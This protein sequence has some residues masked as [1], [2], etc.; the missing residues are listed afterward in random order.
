M[1]THLDGNS[2]SKLCRQRS[3]ALVC[4]R[5]QQLCTAA[6]QLLR[7]IAASFLRGARR[8]ERLCSF[9]AWL[10][11]HAAGRVQQLSLDCS[12]QGAGD[13]QLSA[14]VAAAIS[15]CGAAGSLTALRVKDTLC[16]PGTWTSALRG[17]RRLVAINSHSE[18]ALMAWAV[19]PRALAGLQAL[20]VVGFNAPLDAALP[21]SLTKLHLDYDNQALAMPGTA[22]LPTKLTALT[23][24][25]TLHITCAGGDFAALPQ[26]PS[27]CRLALVQ[28][29]AWPVCL[30]QLTRMQALELANAYGELDDREAAA[31]AVAAALPRLQVTHLLLDWPSNTTGL[32][33]EL[34][35]LTTL[36]SFAWTADRAGL[37]QGP[38][39]QQLRRLAGMGEAI[40]ALAPMLATAAPRLEFLGAL[41]PPPCKELRPLLRWLPRL[42]R[43]RR[44]VL[45]A[46]EASLG[47]AAQALVDA[48]RAA[49]HMQLPSL[50]RCVPPVQCSPALPV[51]FQTLPVHPAPHTWIHNVDGQ[52][53]L[54][55]LLFL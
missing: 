55:S 46:S 37:P 8:P 10:Q 7:S 13:A 40:A 53:P 36:R 49:P 27:L 38:W 6:P 4:R 18:G 24:L 54:L 51:P 5:W 17:L 25:H 3:A 20:H 14:A 16:E 11:Q 26:L 31:A 29:F 44:A 2:T 22:L 39:L 33:A 15:A 32:P 19:A 35:S 48:Q 50:A 1:C 23:R 34:A 21:P 12:G 28:C 45:A 42:P 47:R 52:L 43:L 41:F 30:S 9:C